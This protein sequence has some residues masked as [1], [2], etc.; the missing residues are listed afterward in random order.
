MILKRETFQSNGLN[1]DDQI[2]KLKEV[3]DLYE[4]G[5]INS[6]ELKI[7]KDKILKE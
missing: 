4:N 1:L 7:L 6:D 2:E 3:N 5:I